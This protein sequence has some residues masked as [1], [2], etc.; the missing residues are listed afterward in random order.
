VPPRSYETCGLAYYQAHR[1][2]ESYLGRRHV[3]W[4]GNAQSEEEAVG[5][6]VLADND[7]FTGG[8]VPAP[9]NARSTCGRFFR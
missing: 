8:G 5:S 7:P 6:A 9:P 1:I 3:T 4:A 2:G